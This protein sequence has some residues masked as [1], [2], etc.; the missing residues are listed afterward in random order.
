MSTKKILKKHDPLKALTPWIGMPQKIDTS[1]VL[2][3]I[4]EITNLSNGRKYIGKKSFVTNTTKKVAGKKRRIKITGESNWRYYKSSCD[5]L[6]ADIKAQGI[7]NFRFRVICLCANKLELTYYET[8]HQ[9]KA[10][11]LGALLA[12]GEYKYYNTNILS[13]FFRGK[14]HK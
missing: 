6:K 4:Y 12:N 11:V 9:F 8:L 5:E 14:I 1:K 2:G 7:D 3:F 13:K 10:D